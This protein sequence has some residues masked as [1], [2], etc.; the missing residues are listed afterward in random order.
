MVDDKTIEMILTGEE[1]KV[2]YEKM[3]KVNILNAAEN[4]SKV[5]C[6]APHEKNKFYLTLDGE[7]YHREWIT[8]Y[9]DSIS[10][11]KLK[12]FIE[13]V[14]HEIIMIKEEYNNLPEPSGGYD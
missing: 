13:F 6:V 1:I 11:K 8:S 9:C 14:H 3:K 2:I 4:A 10:D 12:E 7:V 5:Q